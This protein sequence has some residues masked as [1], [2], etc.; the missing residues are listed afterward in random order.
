MSY[1]CTGNIGLSYPAE[2]YIKFFYSLVI[3]TLL[4]LQR[5]KGT[6]SFSTL[7][8]CKVIKLRKARA[9]TNL[10]LTK[11]FLSQPNLVPLLRHFTE[12]LVLELA[13]LGNLQRIFQTI[14]VLVLLSQSLSSGHDNCSNNPCDGYTHG[15]ETS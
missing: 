12:E 1:P 4:V 8:I 13:T 11:L 5:K 2:T 10:K 7:T 14:L 3:H 6:I 15:G 9:A